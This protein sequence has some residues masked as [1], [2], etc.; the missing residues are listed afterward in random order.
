[1]SKA[2]KS[3]T[4]AKGKQPTRAAARRGTAT[5]KRKKSGPIAK[6]K[7]A[8]RAA[9]ARKAREPWITVKPPALAPAASPDHEA[10][11]DYCGEV[12]YSYG[13]LLAQDDMSWTYVYDAFG[14]RVYEGRLGS[15]PP[16][17]SKRKAFKVKARQKRKGSPSVLKSGGK[18]PRSKRPLARHREKR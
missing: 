15:E 7:Q 6:A 13:D 16:R 1:M 17:R 8:A 9:A 11:T 10:G 5:T 14:R 2:K 12:V 3:G 4:I 18:P